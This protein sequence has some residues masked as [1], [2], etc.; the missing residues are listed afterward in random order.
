M[1][2]CEVTIGADRIGVLTFA[3]PVR[4]AGCRFYF[5]TQF[6]EVMFKP[7]VQPFE[8]RVWIALL[9]YVVATALLKWLFHYVL[10]E[11]ADPITA[12]F[13]VIAALLNQ[14]SGDPR[15]CAVRVL[16][17]SLC[18]LF[19]IL[20]IGY[21]AR[22]TATS[23]LRQA[24][25]PY[26]RMEDILAS[27]WG[28]NVISNSFALE[29]MQMSP[30]N[31]TAWKLWQTK[32]DNN[33]YSTVETTEDG[34]W[35]VLDKKKLAFFGFEDACR[36]VLH[37]RFSPDQSCRI[38]ELDGVFFKAPLSFA[39]PRD[40][41]FLLTINYWILRMFET[42]IID[43][44]SRKWLPKP[45]VCDETKYEAETFADVLPMVILFAS[46][47]CL[48]IIVL[49]GEICVYSF[50][51]RNMKVVSKNRKVRKTQ[52]NYLYPML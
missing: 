2:A 6:Q 25:P 47:F 37:R 3:Q 44:L 41:E 18:A 50:K 14:A 22:L 24:A 5:Q 43:R 10:R 8:D 30:P 26:R 32:I 1:S 42:G 11:R 19:L 9:G 27:D 13:A 4:N 45:P 52:K 33:P 21:G 31:S 12:L 20:R 48:A 36:D 28:V 46:G 17:F 34:L 16:Y 39:L 35:N 40:S 49:I 38:S 15:R 23:T 7:Y 29:S 51:N